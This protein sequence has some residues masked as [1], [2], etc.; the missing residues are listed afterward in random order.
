MRFMG[1]SRRGPAARL[2]FWLV[3]V[4]SLA[5]PAAALAHL[6]RPSYWPDPRPD[7]AVTP[8]AG[9]KVPAAR[10]LRSAVTGKGPG[11]V[12]VVCQGRRGGTSMK[13]MRRSI[14]AA[15]AHGFR[16][17]P[18]QPKEHL[19]NSE[20]R[21]LLRMNRALAS[22]C[23]YRRIQE[24]IFDSGNNDRVVVMPG[25]YREK[26]SRRAP[27]ND[28]KC[29]DLIQDNGNGGM[30]PSYRYQVTC[31]N[32]QNLIYIQGRKVPK[33]PPPTPPRAEREGIP[34]LGKCVRCNLQL[35]GS[36]V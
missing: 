27:T 17:R 8:A 21:R 1:R 7:K 26:P 22:D 16:I 29:A 34:D 32:D 13:L 4:A 10:S 36:G 11:Q 30:A 35:E 28:P 20:A 6:E 12:R 2:S 25:R 24:A 18:S 15:Q 23:D 31:P 33:K 3:L 5:L 9:G 14:R 19:S